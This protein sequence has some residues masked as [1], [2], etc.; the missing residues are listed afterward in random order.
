MI[1]KNISEM[2][3]GWVIGHFE[4]SI[5]KTSDFEIG[6][7]NHKKDEV[8]PQHYHKIAT[9][10]NILVSGSMSTCGKE[11]TAGDIFIIEPYEVSQPIFHEDCVVVCIKV[12]S[13]PGDKY[14][15]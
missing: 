9:E 13:I 8:W 11:L 3:R 12:P 6:V 15:L 14:I 2:F 5:F 4:P 1:I 10:Y 7:L